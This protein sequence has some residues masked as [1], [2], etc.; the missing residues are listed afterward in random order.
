MKKIIFYLFTFISMT[1]AFVEVSSYENGTQN[2]SIPNIHLL[3]NGKNISGFK[4]YYFF[5]AADTKNISVESYYLAGG[6]ISVEKISAN[7]YRAEIDFSNIELGAGQ[8][9]PSNGNLQFGLHYS[10][11]SGWN[12]NDDFSNPNNGNQNQSLNNRIVV[13]SS[14]G[15]LLAGQFPSVDDLELAPCVV[16]IY[17]R[18]RNEQNFGKYQLYAKNEGNIPVTH[19]D[20]DV[21]FSSENGAE[22]IIDEWY[23]PN[24]IKTLERKNVNSWI[25][26][27]SVQNVNLEPG[28]IYPNES[29]FSFGVHYADWSN[30]DPLD[31]YAFAEVDADYKVNEKIP[32]YIDNR[33]V[34]GNPKIHD[35]IDIKKIIAIEN[36][37][38]LEEFDTPVKSLIDKTI[39]VP[40]TWNEIE[41]MET[42]VFKRIP[43]FYS[44]SV[45]FVQITEKFPGLEE[46]FL[47]Q[48]FK[49]VRNIYA[50][51]A[52]LRMKAYVSKNQN[53]K[54]RGLLKKAD[55]TYDDTELTSDEFWSLIWSPMRIPGT[56]RASNYALEWAKEYAK[57]R[58]LKNNNTVDNRADGFRHAVWN[59]LI[60]RETG[61]QF[62]DISE[63]LDWAKEFT[64]AHE[65]HSDGDALSTYMDFHNNAIGRNAYGPKLS[66]ECEWDWGFA[67]VNEE[68]VGPSLDE[69]KKMYRDLADIAVGFN[70]KD[71]LKRN[72]WIRRIV[73]FRDDNGKYYCLENEGQEDCQLFENPALNASKI[74]VLKKDLN[75]TCNEEFSFRLDLE[76]DDNGSEIVSGDPNPPGILVGAGGITFTYCVLEM[77]DFDDQIPRVPYDYIVLR[78]DADCPEGTQAFNRHHDTEDSHNA[79]TSTGNLGPNVVTKN[80]T[81]EYCFVPAD[82]NSTLAYP[83]AKEYGVFANYSSTNIV[84]SKIYMDDEDSDNANSWEW[85]DTPSD[86]KERIKIIMN[87]SSNTIY[88][89]VKW[90][91][92][93]WTKIMN[94]M[95]V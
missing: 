68:V 23:M 47:V 93:V 82:E 6:S 91:E 64:D 12:E 26:H 21:E 80:A 95:G 45:A 38:T 37:Y 14:E 20:F 35:L 72:P 61:T 1:F 13:V 52:R 5:S 79:N 39:D 22:P 60:C 51:L 10:D 74:A 54:K 43:D 30:F 83:F 9:F 89:V 32:V 56:R 94:W 29:G 73:F 62:D 71:Q 63:C 78:M 11:W 2:Q 57:D 50:Q 55:Y 3:N 67:C 24:A 34:F 59:A 33:L 18:S 90:I 70:D 25:V 87:G 28:A 85:Y 7:Q 65:Q 17:S 69:T 58:K 8:G 48:N 27:F 36:G 16:K 31:D 81:L 40:K 77:A 42:V 46:R 4:I 44:T 66:V 84:H 92:I 49:D 53:V 88:F 75:F 15:D 19:F 86:I 76:D 41:T